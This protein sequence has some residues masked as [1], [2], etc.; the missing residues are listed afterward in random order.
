MFRGNRFVRAVALALAVFMAVGICPANALAGGEVPDGDI[1]VLWTSM[2][3]YRIQNGAR[4]Y[5][6]IFT[7]DKDCVVTSL[8]TYHY[9]SG[10]A[11]P[12]QLTL[13]AETGEQWGPFQ[14]VGTDGQGGVKNANWIVDT[15]ELA[16][17]AGRYA[18]ADSDPGT[19]S[20]KQIVPAEL[21]WDSLLS[22]THS[23]TGKAKVSPARYRRL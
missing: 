11:K 6:V 20:N 21:H 16:L 19:W 14:A 12:G 13:Y 2:N 1:T 10:G 18:L 7:L 5:Y 23:N 15:G 9:L 4:E 22:Q 17:P 8:M 3:I